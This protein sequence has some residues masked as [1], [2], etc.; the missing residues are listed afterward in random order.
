VFTTHQSKLVSSGIVWIGEIPEHWQIKKLRWTLS[1]PPKNGISPPVSQSGGIPTL[2]IAAVKDG[3]V[4]FGDNVK[5]AQIS[6]RE[7]SPFR[8]RKGDVLALR[9]NGSK[10]LVATC[11]IVGDEVPEGCI[12]PDL[13]I[14]LVPWYKTNPYYFVALMNGPLRDGVELAAKTSAG[15]WKVSGESVSALSVIHQPMSEQ[16]QI[17]D[18][19]KYL[20]NRTRG[21]KDLINRE[22]DQLQTFRSTL[23]SMTV[24]G[25]IKV[26]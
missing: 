25:R 10:H 6:R 22:I 3:K 14:K 7:S 19:V 8:I 16:N 5:Y 9:G 12:Y 26:T 13:L 4:F 23:I 20:D 17:V 2:S 21:I 24:T 15:I 1:S 11:G 18:Y